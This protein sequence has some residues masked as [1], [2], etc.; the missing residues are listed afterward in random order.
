MEMIDKKIFYCWFGG[1]EMSDMD[2]KCI[3]SWLKYCPDYD[4]V[5]ISEENY[6]WESNPYAKQNYEAGNWS[7]VSNAARLDFLSKY[8]GFYLD[9]DVELFR[10]LDDLRVFDG[11]F[12]TEF[13]SGQPDSG[14][15]GRGSKFPNL[16]KEAFEKL[17]PNRILHKEF[18]KVLYRDYDMHGEPV[19]T[20][21]D[22][23]TILG[24]EF[25]PS[26][27]TGLCTKNTVGVHYFENTWKD[28]FIKPSD[29]YYPFP[30]VNVFFAG[31]KILEEKDATVNFTV[32]NHLKKWNNADMIGKAD[33]MLNPRV[34]K[35][36]CKDFEAE[37]INYN[38]FAPQH[39]TVT[40]S[41]LIVTW[42]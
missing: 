23:F 3:A 12:I 5:K 34:I 39:H 8:S 10:S 18:I 30:R 27:R 1:G 24:E 16:Y 19:K 38:R 7:G 26:V 33:Y 4:I 22:G 11:G 25:F 15:L 14:I 35:L 31:A 41:G 40:P 13:E 9:T 21:D 17:V 28:A 2:K 29:G 37:K 36:F 42:I 20:Y 6:D 32:K